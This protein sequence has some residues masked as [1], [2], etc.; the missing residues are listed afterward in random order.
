VDVAGPQGT[1]LQI[2]ELVEDEQ[3]MI[4]EAMGRSAKVG[5][6]TVLAGNR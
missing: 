1:A 4:A 2:T 5:S 6:T 3:R